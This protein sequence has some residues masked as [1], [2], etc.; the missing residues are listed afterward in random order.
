MNNVVV[1]GE[2]REKED[3]IGEEDDGVD[4]HCDA[5]EDSSSFSIGPSAFTAGVGAG[6]SSGGTNKRSRDGHVGAAAAVGAVSTVQAKKMK[7]AMKK[8]GK[9]WAVS[10]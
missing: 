3:T 1:V 8:E 10:N 7:L 9:E 5:D 6:G 4:E 2:N